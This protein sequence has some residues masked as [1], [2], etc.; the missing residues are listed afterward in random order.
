MHSKCHKQKRQTRQRFRLT[1]SLLSSDRT[2]PPS[3]SKLL[4]TTEGSEKPKSSTTTNLD[5]KRKYPKEVVPEV[6]GSLTLQTGCSATQ[7]M[8][9]AVAID[10]FYCTSTTLDAKDQH[11]FFYPFTSFIETAFNAESL[12]WMTSTTVFRHREAIVER[13]RR[14]VVHGLTM[15]TTLAYC[16]SC[17]RWAIGEKERER[18]PEY[19]VLKAIEAL[20]I[21]L[22]RVDVL[23]TWLILSIY[24]LAVSDMWAQNY[25]AATSHLKM[26]RHLVTQYGGLMKL[27]PYLMESI[28]LCDKYVAIGRF[29]V[30]V[31]PLDWE[32]G[33]LPKWNMPNSQGRVD[34]L[35][36]ELAQRFYDLDKHLLG[37]NMLRIIDDI[38]VCA[39]VSQQWGTQEISDPPDQHW[40]FRHQAIFWRLLSIPAASETQKCCR[41][42]LIIRLLKIT[43]YLG[44]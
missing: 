7:N 29:E 20:R 24:A 11:L 4:R 41:V 6:P 10:P 42:A 13:L 18:P 16:A 19:Y 36:L 8:I 14:C 34:A 22:E 35:L 25:E 40:L 12:L 17:M 32:P 38:R 23:D 28:L 26:T 37:P 27:Q 30:P 1:K 33:S 2:A 31:F 44:A 9:D 39:Q 15:Y 5:S 43:V 3:T 21:R